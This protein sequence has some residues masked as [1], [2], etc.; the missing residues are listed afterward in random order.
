MV[1]AMKASLIAIQEMEAAGP[2]AQ[3]AKGE[4]GA[5]AGVGLPRTKLL[6]HF[7]LQGGALDGPEALET[8]AGDGHFLDQGPLGFVSRTEVALEGAEEVKEGLEIL[9]FEDDGAGEKAM[10]Q[11]VGGGTAFVSGVL[12]VLGVLG[13][14]DLAPLA[15]EARI[16]RSELIL[17]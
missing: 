6:L 12:G 14:R 4:G 9:V 13:P 15:R 5:G 7:G 16:L 1:L 11:V 2:V 17:F 3:G 8:P 10:A